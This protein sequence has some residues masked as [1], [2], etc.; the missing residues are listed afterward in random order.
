MHTLEDLSLEASVLP[1]H[2]I[3]VRRFTFFRPSF[4][5]EPVMYDIKRLIL[6]KRSTYHY[7]DMTGL[8]TGPEYSD[9]LLQSIPGI[10]VIDHITDLYKPDGTP[11]KVPGVNQDGLITEYRR[12]NRMIRPTRDPSKQEDDERGLIIYNYS[13]LT[14][15]WRYPTNF[16]AEW[17]KWLNIHKTLFNNLVKVVGESDRHQFLDFQLP[18]RIPPLGRLREF[19][20]NKSTA[21]LKALRHEGDF[22]VA[23]LFNFL[24]DDPDSS[25]L[26]GIPKEAYSKINF[27]LR[28]NDSWVVI[29]LGWLVELGTTSGINPKTL[30]IRFL[31]MLNKL[32]DVSSII[33]PSDV[34]NDVESDE[35]DEDA[36][37]TE[38]EVDEVAANLSTGYLDDLIESDEL[39]DDVAEE[40]NAEKELAELDR[41]RESAKAERLSMD[42]DEDGVGEDQ[43]Y[44]VDGFARDAEVPPVI[45][46]ANELLSKNAITPAGY[47]R[48][49]RAQDR[50]ESILDPNGSGKT[51][52]EAMELTEEQSAVHEEVI[53]TAEEVQDPTMRIS[54]VDSYH[55][56]YINNVFKK[57]VM[58]VISSIQNFP[59]A[60]TDYKIEDK[61]TAI[62][63]IEEH[64]VRVIPAVGVPVTLR[65]PVPKL[66]EDG[67]FRYSNKDFRMRLQRAD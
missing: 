4:L 45:A 50:F 11:I 22:L 49:L 19:S 36:K 47:K 51:L 65:I 21:S 38:E 59:V 63:G 14:R 31:L 8:K 18:E 30:Q 6:P 24:G 26:S 46:K 5:N 2:E 16:K 54:R 58:S 23:E 15:T 64:V 42:D 9:P 61:S 33:K 35:D 13:L 55:K 17:T 62:N 28:N 57:D 25:L 48:L 29:N 43:R 32:L 10:K 67:T 52:I 60:I 20:R 7:V 66:K 41:I 12:F 34:D 56:T 37:A 53:S 44:D 3:Y 39:L 40:R 1:M 27:I